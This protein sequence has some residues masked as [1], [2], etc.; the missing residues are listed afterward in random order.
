MTEKGRKGHVT[1]K[2]MELTDK[3]HILTRD[4]L[5]KK[6]DINTLTLIMDEIR[7]KSVAKIVNEYCETPD[8]RIKL[9]VRR[10]ND[11][12]IYRMITNVEKKITNLESKGWFNIIDY[13]PDEYDI[14]N[15]EN[16]YKSQI[17][18][19]KMTQH[20]AK[21]GNAVPSHADMSLLCYSCD[22][23]AHVVTNDSDITTF[24]PELKSE[25]ICFDVIKISD[26]R[27]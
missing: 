15:V 17:G 9:G 23:S 21:K 26:V 18:T 5:T 11:A 6:I 3:I 20:I 13:D 4:L 14:K 25:G 8:A 19:A 22:N 16:F 2:Y 10:V 1:L 7:R 12:A 24:T 27:F